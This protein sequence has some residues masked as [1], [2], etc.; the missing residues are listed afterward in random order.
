MRRSWLDDTEGG[1]IAHRLHLVMSPAW[2]LA[3]IPLRRVLERLEIEHMRHAGKENGRLVVSYDQFVK[4]G[5]SR[6]AIRGALELGERLGLLEVRQTHEWVGDVRPPNQYRLT[7]VPE[8]DRKAP[9]DEWASLA[10]EK[11]KSIIGG[12]YS[13]SEAQFPFRPDTSSLSGHQEASTSALF[14]Q[15]PVPNRELSLI[16]GRKGHDGAKDRSHS[17]SHHKR[18]DATDPPPNHRT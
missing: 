10:E 13:K 1:W 2:R 14:A 15:S 7:Y 3:P 18:S 12:K 9:T 5:V 16:S 8:K 4:F 17:V 6:K 11:V